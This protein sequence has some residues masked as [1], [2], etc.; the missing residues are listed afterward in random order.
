MVKAT[1]R[2]Q[3]MME[4]MR[5]ELIRQQAYIDAMPGLRGVSC[6]VKLKPNGDVRAVLVTMECSTDEA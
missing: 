5:N 4:A 2:S 1:T 6:I 3:R